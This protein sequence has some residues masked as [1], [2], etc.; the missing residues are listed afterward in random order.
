MK[1]EKLVGDDFLKLLVYR[2]LRFCVGRFAKKK[3]DV[4]N[5]LEVIRLNNFSRLVG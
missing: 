2:L 4:N 3:N 5:F 1:F